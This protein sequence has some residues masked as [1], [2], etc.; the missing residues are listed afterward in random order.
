MKPEC[1][2]P[3]YGGCDG[4]GMT[5]V[6]DIVARGTH[7]ERI[8][9][10]T[11]I[12][13]LVDAFYETMGT[14]SRAAAIRAMHEPDLTATRAVLI[15]YLTEWM[16][17]PRR[18]SPVRGAPALRKR[19]LRFAIDSAARDAWMHCMRTA[20][21]TVCVDDGLRGELEKAFQRVAEAVRNTN[22]PIHPPTERETM[23]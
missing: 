5:P 14:D 10:E 15:D 23:P 19:H 21:E 1:F 4:T 13:A 8:G 20:L 6:T 22:P 18:Y 3:W 12:S 2:S 9:G 16:G 17:G 11:A 7:F